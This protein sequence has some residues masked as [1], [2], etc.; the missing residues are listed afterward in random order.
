MTAMDVPWGVGGP[1]AHSS[2]SRAMKDVC[3]CMCACKGTFDSTLLSNLLIASNTSSGLT[4]PT[5]MT[6]R[7][8]GR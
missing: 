5:T 3:V 7:L 4:F 6:A 8:S 1:G 2:V